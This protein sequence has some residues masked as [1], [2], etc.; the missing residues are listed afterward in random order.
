MAWIINNEVTLEFGLRTATVYNNKYP[1]LHVDLSITAGEL[2]RILLMAKGEMVTYNWLIYLIW[3]RKDGRGS[4]NNLTLNIMRV[5]DALEVVGLDRTSIVNLP[6]KGY[7]CTLESQESILSTRDAIVPSGGDNITLK[8]RKYFL[9]LFCIFIFILTGYTISPRP[10]MIDGAFYLFSDGS[11]NIYT[12]DMLPQSLKN[13]VI[14]EYKNNL[15]QNI[16]GCSSTEIGL[17]Y[18][19]DAF[20]HQPRHGFFYAKCQTQGSTLLSCQSYFRR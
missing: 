15:P 13:R 7:C 11:C 6:G 14:D 12:F 10:K 9:I 4:Y 16:K 3:A 20:E 17:I 5:R 18:I 1:D 19:N 8:Y 2:L